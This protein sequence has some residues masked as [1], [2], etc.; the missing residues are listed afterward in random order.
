MTMNTKIGPM[1]SYI[2]MLGMTPCIRPED[3][4]S[5]IKI[6]DNHDL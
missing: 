1:V 4:R 2:H 6:D 3:M 5:V